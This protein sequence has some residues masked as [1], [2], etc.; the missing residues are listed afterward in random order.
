MVWSLPGT[1]TASDSGGIMWSL[2]KTFKLVSVADKSGKEYKILSRRLV[3]EVIQNS[4][5]Q[6]SLRSNTKFSVAD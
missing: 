2:K 4:Q 6:T 5:S 1:N 3:C